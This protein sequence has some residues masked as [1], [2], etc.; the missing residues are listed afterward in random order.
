MTTAHSGTT[1]ERQATA[2]NV[3]VLLVNLGTPDTADTRG[4]RDYLREF[5]SDPRVIGTQSAGRHAIVYGATKRDDTNG[6][7][8]QAEQDLVE[9]EPCVL[10]A[11]HKQQ[12]PRARSRE[13]TLPPTIHHGRQM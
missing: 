13:N 3:G 2:T 1:I 4:V 7:N 5:L 11:A 6:K 8:S 12:F 10:S 9:S